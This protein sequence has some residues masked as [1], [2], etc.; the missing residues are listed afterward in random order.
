VAEAL[1]FLSGGEQC[2]FKSLEGLCQKGLLVVPQL[3][4]VGRCPRQ[5]LDLSLFVFNVPLTQ[6]LN[7]HLKIRQAEKVRVMLP[8]ARFEVCPPGDK[9]IQLPLLRGEILPRD[10]E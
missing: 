3:L 10:H 9:R 6:T 4:Q 7:N 5:L 1:E 8:Q 2:R